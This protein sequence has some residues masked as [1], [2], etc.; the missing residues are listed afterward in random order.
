MRRPCVLQMQAQTCCMECRQ[1]P[2]MCGFWDCSITTG[3]YWQQRCWSALFCSWETSGGSAGAIEDHLTAEACDVLL[4]SSQ[5]A[6]VLQTRQHTI[7][8]G[9]QLYLCPLP[10]CAGDGILRP[11][12]I[13]PARPGEPT[14]AHV[15]LYAS[16]LSP[17]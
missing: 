14:G 11:C 12:K 3:Q 2:Q 17:C 5:A 8:S 13:A 1:S 4:L 6:A 10:L 15:L 7:G 16:P 9:H